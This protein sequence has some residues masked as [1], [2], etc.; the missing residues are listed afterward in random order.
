LK[1]LKKIFISWHNPF[2]ITH[3]ARD[4]VGMTSPTI[5]SFNG[6]LMGRN[7]QQ[8]KRSSAVLKDIIKIYKYSGSTLLNQSVMRK[9]WR[10]CRYGTYLFLLSKHE[11]SEN[12]VQF[13][14]K[15]LECWTIPFCIDPYR[16]L[17]TAT[18]LDEVAPVIMFSPR[19][20][21]A[22][23]STDILYSRAKGDRRGIQ[24]DRLY[25]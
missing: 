10:G 1:T 24:K 22:L 23:F 12:L 18:V 17:Y 14:A 7:R 5:I 6:E 16:T 9:V 15:K 21:D 19:G 8:K 3:L 4:W 11:I 2:N 25:E 13:V 20:I